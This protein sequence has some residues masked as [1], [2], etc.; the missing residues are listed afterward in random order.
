MDLQ[1]RFL[2]KFFNFKLSVAVD[3]FGAHINGTSL[4]PNLRF[5]KPNL[6]L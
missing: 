6:N 2:N 1:I 5:K 3:K 4:A